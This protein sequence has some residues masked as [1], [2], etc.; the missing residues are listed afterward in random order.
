[1]P[2]KGKGGKGGKG[3]CLFAVLLLAVS[4]EMFALR[5]THLL[6]VEDVLRLK[7]RFK[8]TPNNLAT[9]LMVVESSLLFMV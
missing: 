8:I 7:K 1:M 3:Q 2:P 4:S 6:A 9:A 5:K